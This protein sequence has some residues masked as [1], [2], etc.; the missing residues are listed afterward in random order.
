M[1]I[2]RYSP[3]RCFVQ[4]ACVSFTVKALTFAG[5]GLHRSHIMFYVI[6]GYV[7]A[8]F[9]LH[10][11]YVV[12]AA[13]AL[14]SS[15]RETVLWLPCHPGENKYVCSSYCSLSLLAASSLVPCLSWV[16]RTVHTVWTEDNWCHKQ[17][18]QCKW[19]SQQDE[20]QYNDR[21]QTTGK[22][23]WENTKYD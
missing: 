1:R 20:K 11:G 21:R 22:G 6:W 15:R 9:W 23:S 10:Y 2:T 7:L 17:D 4:Y 3:T 16:Q 14:V 18:Q 8:V 12:A 13:T 19:H 5:L